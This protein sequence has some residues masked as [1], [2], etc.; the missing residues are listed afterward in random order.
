[1]SLTESAF[2]W[3]C[4]RVDLHEDIHQMTPRGVQQVLIGCR[5]IYL[6]G[7]FKCLR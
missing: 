4:D 3:V 6:I 1:M 7:D 2:M 5:W